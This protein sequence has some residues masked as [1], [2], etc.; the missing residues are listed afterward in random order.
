MRVRLTVRVGLMLAGLVGFL[1][2]S[3]ALAQDD[4]PISTS[5]SNVGYIDSA[6]PMTQIRF[7]Y[8]SAYNNPSPDRNQFFYAEDG[9]GGLRNETSV[10]Y[11]DIRTFI[12]F[13]PSCRFSIFAEIPVRFLNPEQNANTAGLGDLD[14]GI[15]FAVRSCPDDY[16]TLQFRT[17][18]PTGDAV[19]R[20]LGTSNVNLEPG[21]LFFRRLSDRLATEGE[22]KVWIPISNNNVRT[23]PFTGQDFSG[24]VVRYGIGAGYDIFQQYGCC[25]CCTPDSRLT[26]VVELVGWTILDGFGTFAVGPPQ[27]VSG[28]TMV[29]VKLGLRYTSDNKSFYAGYGR[30]L[31]GDV[32]YT[33]IFRAEF[34]LTF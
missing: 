2:A 12:E 4:L 8:D 6:I 10:D 28:D 11:Q 22:L 31:T 15:K 1:C 7:R 13:A 26:G 32:W 21:V 23:G 27:D 30:A 14:A 33:D 25:D 19:Q 34:R 16:L 20:G 29:N 3:T 5:S 18:V 17:Y 9:P 24:E